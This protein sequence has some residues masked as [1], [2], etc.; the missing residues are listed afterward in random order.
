MARPVETGSDT[1]VH[2][3]LDDGGFLAVRPKTRL[4]IRE[5]KMLGGVDDFLA[6]IQG[7]LRSITDWVGKLDRSRYR[8]T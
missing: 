7:A 5:V 2:V 6:L 1:E 8:I 3:V 4:Q